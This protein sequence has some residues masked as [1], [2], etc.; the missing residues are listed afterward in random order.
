MLEI[1]KHRLEKLVPQ[2][3]T[4]L[5]DFHEEG[6][7]NKTKQLIHHLYWHENMSAKDVAKLT[8]KNVKII[9]KLAGPTFVKQTCDTC[10]ENFV[11][12]VE[13]KNQTI[14]TTCNNCKYNAYQKNQAKVLTLYLGKSVPKDYHKYLQRLDCSL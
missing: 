12:Q 7:E 6:D 9:W 8:Q 11:I 3:Q 10:K 1:H 14:Q 5:S 4:T 13:S 2:V